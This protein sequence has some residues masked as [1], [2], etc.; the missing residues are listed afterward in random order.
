MTRTR[1]KNCGGGAGSEISG[2]QDAEP[3]FEDRGNSKTRNGTEPAMELV[4]KEWSRHDFY[5]ARFL[6]F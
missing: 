3:E 4:D 1:Q 2:R 6:W 5:R